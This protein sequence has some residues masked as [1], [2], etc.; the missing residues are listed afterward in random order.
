M[1]PA[2]PRTSSGG[3]LTV[4]R[5]VEAPQPDSLKP[6]F[7][8]P[9]IEPLRPF[10]RPA[11]VPPAMVILVPLPSAWTS[12]SLQNEREISELLGIPYDDYS[13]AGLFPVAYTIGTDFKPGARA[14]SDDVRHRIEQIVFDYLGRQ[15]GE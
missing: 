4:A 8:T 7:V 2:A 12:L 3:A 1:T 6:E 10:S 14:L 11:A 15:S 13:Q 5:Q 9:L